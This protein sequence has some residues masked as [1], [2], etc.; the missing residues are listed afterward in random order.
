MDLDYTELR[1][2]GTGIGE[3][4]ADFIRAG[5]GRDIDVFRLP[6]QKE[7]PY[8]PSGKEGFVSVQTKFLDNSPCSFFHLT[9]NIYATASAVRLADAHTFCRLR[10]RIKN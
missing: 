4:T 1:P 7:V 9:L 10:E 6:A 2:H 8:P 3:Q 5:V